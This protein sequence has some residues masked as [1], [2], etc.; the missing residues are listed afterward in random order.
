MVNFTRKKD[1]DLNATYNIGVYSIADCVFTIN[2]IVERYVSG[3][4]PEIE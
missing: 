1:G 3:N 2:V 4:V